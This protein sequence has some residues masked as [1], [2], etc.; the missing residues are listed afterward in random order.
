MD[1]QITKINQS[2]NTAEEMRKQTQYI[3]QPYANWEEYLTPIPLSIAIMAELACLSSN[4]DFSINKNPPKDGYKYIRHPDSFCACLM[5]VCN[6]G[7]WAFNEAHK[8]MD[9]IRLHTLNVPTFMKNV[10]KILFEGSN[11]I[12]QAHL[13]DQLE[14]IHVIADECLQLAN[15][16][17]RRFAD[18]INIIQELLEVCIKARNLYGEEVEEIKKKLEESKL[19]QDTSNEAVK[20]SQKVVKTMEEEL[21]EARQS[22]KAA[23]N[24][25]PGGWEMMAMDF[26]GA[27]T[28]SI[29]SVFNGLSALVTQPV[30]KACK[31]TTKIADTVSQIKSENTAADPVDEIN[32]YS[33]SREILKCAEIIE[34]FVQEDKINW[35]GLH[36][37]KNNATVTDF[38]AKQFE[39]IL[40]NLEKIP[41]CASKHNAQ[42]LCKNGIEICQELAKY[43]PAGEC[44]EAT[45]LS[46]IKRIQDLTKVACTFDSRSKDVAKCPSLTPKLPM[47]YKE[48]AKMEKMTTSQK[49]SKNARFRI[50]QTRVQMNKTRELY[51]RSVENMEKNQKELTEILITMRNCKVKEID[52]NTAIQM[53]VRGL[54]AM[55]KVKQQWEKMVHFFQMVSNIVKTSLHTSLKEFTTTSEK[56][57]ALSY[58]EKLFSKDLLYSQA[59]QATNVASLVHM[60]SN[61]YTEVSSKHLMDSVSSLGM[62]LSMDRESPGF[63]QKRSELQD[64]CDMAQNAILCLVLKNKNEFERKTNSRLE[65]IDRELLV[66]LPA[67]K[68]EEIQHIQE[69]TQS[70]FTEEEVSEYA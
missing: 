55:G 23:M 49:A 39:R 3:M 44:D 21:K 52:F 28:D 66:I 46:L 37:Q 62:L 29:S 6:S 11:N 32:V 53:L 50:E 17:E 57:Q 8:N 38:P 33:K 4:S 9:Q 68:P 24:S 15:S 20:R 26:I 41:N 69:A 18:V 59:F 61:T 16:T 35:D 2:L 19:R 5:Q 65:K 25:L 10:V 40:T 58:N 22:Y 42:S 67:A 56:T 70:G 64:S 14:N 34:Q 27:V 54:D 60:I 45:T 1:S 63:M 31:A 36:D 48:E 7:W 30:S 47:M 51:D 12:I 43:A 13:P